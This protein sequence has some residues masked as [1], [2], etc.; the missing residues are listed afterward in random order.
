[1]GM[2]PIEALVAGQEEK[3]SASPSSAPLREC[4]WLAERPP[5][6]VGPPCIS[7]W[8][9]T[10]AATYRPDYRLAFTLAGRYS[11]ML[12]TTL[13]NADVNPNTYQGFASWFVGDARATYRLDRHWSGSLG[14]DNVLSRKY[15]LFHPFPHRTFVGNLTYP[16]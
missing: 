15:F 2:M 3:A 1:M 6:Y 10:F 4:R 16:L 13:D 5:S 12:Y 11:G 9:G 14:V 7:E 8:R